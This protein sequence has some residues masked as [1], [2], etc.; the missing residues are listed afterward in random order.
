MRFAKEGYIWVIP[1]L[2]IDIWW[3]I[4]SL[5][6]KYNPWLYFWVITAP[7]CCGIILLASFFRDPTR[8]TPTNFQSDRHV[9][10]P[11]DGSICAIDYGGESLSIFVEMHYYNVH[12]VRAPTDV[13]VRDII[14]QKGRHHL[15]YFFKKS[16]D[17]ATRAI[18]KNARTLLILETKSGQKMEYY[19]ICGAFFRRAKPYVHIGDKLKAGDRVGMIVFGST[20]K[21]TFLKAN[22]RIKVKIGDRVKAGM[23]ILCEQ[24]N[25]NG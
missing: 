5:P 10:S 17:S 25:E 24:V 16:T 6:T 18:R 15:V 23:S 1:L 3:H 14:R 22:Y 19:M 21:L 12:V 2:L 4:I 8:I 20:V 7:T 9:L 13:A 11:A